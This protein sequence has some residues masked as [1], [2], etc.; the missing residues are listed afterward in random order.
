MDVLAWTQNL[1][2]RLLPSASSSIS[3]AAEVQHHAAEQGNPS[4]LE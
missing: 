2:A 3:Q 4:G 1:D